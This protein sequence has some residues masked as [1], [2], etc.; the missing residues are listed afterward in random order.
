MELEPRPTPT[1]KD[2]AKATSE[3]LDEAT[4]KAAEAALGRPFPAALVLLYRSE[5]NGGKL[6]RSLFPSDQPGLEGGAQIG[7]LLGIG[8][9]RGLPALSVLKKAW[10]YPGEGTLLASE[11]PRGLLLEPPDPASGAEAVVYVDMKHP[12]GPLCVTLAA[13][14]EA[15][16]AGLVDGSPSCDWV[17]QPDLRAIQ[18]RVCAAGWVEGDNHYGI[19]R[20]AHP[21]LAGLDLRVFPN[22]SR[23]GEGFACAEFPECALIA[24]LH[25]SREARQALLD[26]AADLDGV[27]GA[28]TLRVN[29][30]H[31]AAKPVD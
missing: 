14:F 16:A 31:P 7:Y 28:G 27:L 12:A 25:G 21:A 30:P 19:R 11:G 22:Q 18:E 24:Q 17:L 9:P 10:K 26:A 1:F 4:L 20:F 3:P 13:S 15:F 6:R 2:P 29:T 8:G 23:D 5:Q